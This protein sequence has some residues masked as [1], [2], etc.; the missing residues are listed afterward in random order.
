M[1]RTA[2]RVFCRI[3]EVFVGFCFLGVVGLTFM[4]A[5][6]RYFGRPLTT[7]EDLCLFLFPWAA[8]F[9]ADVAL[10]HSRLVGMDLFV[11]KLSPKKQKSIQILI[12]SIMIVVMVAII[13]LGYR[14]ALSNWNRIMNSLPISYGF[15]TISFPTACIFMIL[16][17]IL[18]IKR[19]VQ[20][21]NNDS[22]NIKKDILG[23]P[24]P[25][26]SPVNNKDHDDGNNT[27][28]EKSCS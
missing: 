24:I 27:K 17:C 7:A 8:F 2:Y 22:Y 15:V 26:F 13:P 6:L 5:V 12:F 25:G 4:N 20:N 14:L 28:A 21:F 19:I 9:G 10:R 16:T 11:S 18:R 3:E 23:A 1:I